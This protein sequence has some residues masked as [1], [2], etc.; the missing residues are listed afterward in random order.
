M[1]LGSGIDLLQQRA[2]LVKALLIAGFV[3]VIAVM[4]GEIAEYGGVISLDEVEL[5]PPAQL[6]ASVALL[7]VAVTIATIIFFSM[8]I[9]R[10][11]ANV[12]AAEVVGF[13]YTPGWSVGWFFI[14]I[15]NLVKPFQAM[16]QIW[17]A[18]HGHRADALDHGNGLLTI[19]WATWL[20]SNIANNISTRLSLRADTID[21]A[22]LATM[23]G[24]VGSVVSLILYPSALRL[25]DRITIAQ[26]EKLTAS[27]IFS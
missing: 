25:V 26:R 22:Q 14:P 27:H 15:A 17:N 5:S 4:V 7:S 18:S 24:I 2:K 1:D 21:D 6:Y 11:A 13:D 10:A 9:Y 12:A 3:L 8:W 23:F 16:R 20:V 19:W